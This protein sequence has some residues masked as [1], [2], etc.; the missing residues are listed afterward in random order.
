LVYCHYW[1][2]PAE[3]SLSGFRTFAQECVRRR[4]ALG[5]PWLGLLGGVKIGNAFGQGRPMF[6]QGVISFDGRP[7]DEPLS[8]HRLFHE[9]QQEP[10][11]FNLYWDFVKTNQKPY[12]DLVVA[13]LVS[14]E[15]HFAGA[16]LSSEGGKRDWARGIAL[17]E[18]AA[19]R[20]APGSMS[21]VRHGRPR[22]PKPHSAGRQLRIH[23]G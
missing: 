17:Y 9:P 4:R 23:Y 16:A 3:L 22:C 10:D 7:S 14:F 1:G 19:G 5:V 15:M 2:R 12:D 13:A 21:W 6:R 18:R 8:I 11:R 20:Q